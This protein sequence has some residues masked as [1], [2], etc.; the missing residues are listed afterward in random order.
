MIII[1]TNLNPYKYKYHNVGYTNTHSG[2]SYVYNGE[3][4]QRKEIYTIMN[5][6]LQSKRK[7]L[8]R[9]YNEIKNF[10]SDEQNKI[11]NDRWNKFIKQ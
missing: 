11:I 9:I 2:Y 8:L 1:E 4:W 6:L 5:D 10:L 7:D 3:T